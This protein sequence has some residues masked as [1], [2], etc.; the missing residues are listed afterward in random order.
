MLI[1]ALSGSYSIPVVLGRPHWYLGPLG[2]KVLKPS[3]NNNNNNNNNNKNDIN[4]QRSAFAGPDK[5]P[6][7]PTTGGLDE[8]P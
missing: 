6:T 2:T 7:N 5:L 8:I 4:C 3:N 1:L